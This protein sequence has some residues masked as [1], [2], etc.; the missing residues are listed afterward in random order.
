LTIQSK[1][2]IAISKI[3]ACVN[4]A[5]LNDSAFTNGESGYDSEIK[6]FG[7]C[8]DTADMKEGTTAFMEKRKANFT[9]K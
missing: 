5:D 1:A 3:I 7:D 9:G 6:A 8:F 4:I 2:P